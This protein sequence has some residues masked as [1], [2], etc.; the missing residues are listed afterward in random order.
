MTKEQDGVFTSAEKKIDVHTQI[1]QI[2]NANPSELKKV[3]DNLSYIDQVQRHNIPRDVEK[4]T[5]FGVEV[6]DLHD[7]FKD[8]IW[9]RSVF[10]TD[11]IVNMCIETSI[12]RMKKY[13]PKKT[14]ANMQFWWLIILLVLGVGAMFLILVFIL[15]MLGGVSLF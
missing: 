10:T 5:V 15:P 8:N 9:D 3:A 1:D 14:K 4:H 13:L 2:L 7:I 12:E 11:A 6:F